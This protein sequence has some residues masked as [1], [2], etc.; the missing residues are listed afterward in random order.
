MGEEGEGK[1]G[2]GGMVRFTK[3]AA[4]TEIEWKKHIE[5]SLCCRLAFLHIMNTH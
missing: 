4:L 3:E 2:E 5:L 1:E